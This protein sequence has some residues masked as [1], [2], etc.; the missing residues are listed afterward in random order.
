MASGFWVVAK[1]KG[2]REHWAA[3]NVARQGFEFYLP[4]TAATAPRKIT[5]TPPKPQCLFPRY[6]FV[7]TVGQWRC[8]LG[9]FGVT[10]LIMQGET[11]AILPGKAVEQLRARTGPE[12]LIRLPEA[13][14]ERFSPGDGIR[15][16]GGAFSGLS[17]I[18]QHHGEGDRARILLDFL[19]RKTRV[20]VGEEHL[21]AV[22]G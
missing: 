12:G 10:G 21:E 9:T 15:V 8:L 17:G 1:T 18:Y 16:N 4:L 13:P 5:K 11:P 22:H 7:W 6:L 14:L 2:Q 3:E 20:L 19:G